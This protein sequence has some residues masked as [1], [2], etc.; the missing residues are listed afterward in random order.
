MTPRLLALDTCLVS[1]ALDALGLPG[2][3]TGIRPLHGTA[4]TV[5]GAAVT[6]RIGPRGSAAPAHHLATPAVAASGPGQ[7]LVIGNQG[8]TDVSAWGGILSFAAARRGIEGVVVDGAARDIGEAEELGFPVYGRAA[9]PVTAR[10][11]IV[12]E[13]WDVPVDFAGVTV[14]P[15]D[16][17]LADVNG[18]VF[19]PRDRADEVI[20]VA[21]RLAARERAMI[22]AVRAGESVVDVMHDSRFEEATR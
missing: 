2:A 19:V 10:G 21:E 9:V 17:V 11:R 3:T 15:G 18:V 7:V 8:R 1:D 22:E 4:R 6:V 5:A 14:D 16:L 13:A 12:Q 20:A